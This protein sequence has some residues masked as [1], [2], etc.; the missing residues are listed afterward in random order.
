MDPPSSPREQL[1][2]YGLLQGELELI[3]WLLDLMVSVALKETENDM[4]VRAIGKGN[5][6]DLVTSMAPSLYPISSDQTDGSALMYCFVSYLYA[7]VFDRFKVIEME[8]KSKC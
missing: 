8:I 1:K 6:A 4:N 3:D 5:D 2:G 7:M